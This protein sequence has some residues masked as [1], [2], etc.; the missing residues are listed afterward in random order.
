MGTSCSDDTLRNADG[1]SLFHRRQ[2]RVGSFTRERTRRSPGLLAVATGVLV[3]LA[4]GCGDVPQGNG[5]GLDAASSHPSRPSIL[6]VTLDT[7][8]AD[9]VGRAGGPAKTPALDDLAARGRTLDG[10]AT[11]PM[12][13]P[14]HASMLTG[15]YP[16]EHRVHENARVLDPGVPL[17]AERLSGAGYRTAAFVSAAPLASTFGLDRGFEVYDDDFG[18]RDER[19]ADETTDRAL[20]HLRSLR[21]SPAGTPVF[22]WV[23]YF[24]PH[25]PYLDHGPEHRPTDAG[26]YGELGPSVASRYL[27][28]VS[29]MDRALGRLVDGFEEG[30]DGEV[31]ILVV[32]DHGESLGEHGE[33]THGALLHEGVL[34]VPMIVVGG[35]PVGV[36]GTKGSGEA[37]VS[38]RAVHGTALDW[39][40]LSH[41][42]VS[43]LAEGEAVVLAEAMQPHLQYGWQPHVA[44]ISA[45]DRAVLFGSQETGVS[46]LAFDLRT[47]AADALPAELRSA[48]R[49]YPA[50]DPAANGSEEDVPAELRARLSRLGYVTGSAA[51]RRDDPPR[52]IDRTDVFDELEAA[53]AAFEQDTGCINIIDFDLTPDTDGAGTQVERAVIKAVNLTPANYLKN[54]MNLRSMEAIFTR[55]ARTA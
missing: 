14:S 37:P 10:W 20:R 22:L 36:E 11:A 28:E 33:S 1:I 53:S 39:A 27:S 35:D 15:L 13:L 50:P 43:A 31:R 34:A 40:G 2:S 9:A 32:G 4:V 52:A 38:V 30:S 54:G 51:P 47:D 29:F 3:H 19:P 18:D 12:T 49:S 5:K 45:Q 8:R 17:L 41:D 7:T 21:D 26:T 25:A 24:D 42:S 55:T 46:V 48:L 16:S 44:A 23:H 6:L